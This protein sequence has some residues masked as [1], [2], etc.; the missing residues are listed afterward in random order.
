MGKA[1]NDIAYYVGN[2]SWQ[3][4]IDELETKMSFEIAKSDT[5][6]EFNLSG[7]FIKILN[8]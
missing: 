1:T 4:S 7:E 6:Y 5:N 2:L 3:N 8:D